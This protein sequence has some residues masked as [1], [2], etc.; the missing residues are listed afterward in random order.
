[1]A[2]VVFHLLLIVRAYAPL[3]VKPTQR[4]CCFMHLWSAER[5]LNSLQ[6]RSGVQTTL[7]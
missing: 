4:Q 3:L 7:K 1:M 6:T 5:L 2:A